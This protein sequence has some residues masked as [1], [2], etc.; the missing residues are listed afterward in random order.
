MFTT[1]VGF[2]RTSKGFISVHVGKLSAITD[3]YTCSVWV[4]N[5]KE[6]LKIQV[7]SSR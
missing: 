7:G 4:A 2:L 5:A 1:F 3:I 6:I